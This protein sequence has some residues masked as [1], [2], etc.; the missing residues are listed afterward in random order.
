MSNDEN[1]ENNGSNPCRTASS[2]SVWAAATHS[3]PDDL[4]PEASLPALAAGVFFSYGV[5]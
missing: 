1:T 5:E 4:R 3:T 2:P